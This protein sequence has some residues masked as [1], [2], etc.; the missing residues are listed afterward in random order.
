MASIKTSALEDYAHASSLDRR[1]REKQAVPLY[2]SAIGKGLKGSHLE[3]ALLGL[4]SS[5]RCLGRDR[6]AVAV[7]RKGVRKFPQSRAIQVFLAM[8]LYQQG[9][10]GAAMKI[11]LKNL[12]ETS[13]NK[14]IA[15]YRK[16][17]LFYARKF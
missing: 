2:E 11:L 5:Y 3:G 15:Q 4:G 17:I 13:S 14:S 1:G 7:L 8:A 10:P 12:A 9:K 16:A 6:E